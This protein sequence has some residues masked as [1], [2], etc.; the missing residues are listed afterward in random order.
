MLV[1]LF[2][3]LLSGYPVA[4]ILSGVAL[5]CAS[6]GYLFDVF[7]IQYLLFLPERIFGLMT[8]D[9][10]FSI[11]LFILM[12]AFL[13]HSHAAEKF[14]LYFSSLFHNFPAGVGI[15]VILVGALIAASTGVIGATVVAMGM[16][17]L[18]VMLQQHYH[19]RF[20]SGIVVAAGSLGQ[21][22]PPSIML[23]I[24]SEVMNNAYQEASSSGSVGMPVDAIVVSPGSFFA[25]AIL[26]SILLIIL[27]ILFIA[28]FASS[29]KTHSL[30]IKI[31]SS[32]PMIKRTLSDLLPLLLIMSVLG[33]ILSGV[34]TPSEASSIG[35]VGA[36]LIGTRSENTYKCPCILGFLSAAALFLISFFV[37]IRLNQTSFTLWEGLGIALCLC[38]F[39]L[40]FICIVVAFYQG[41]KSLLIQKASRT[42]L[43]FTGMIFMI[44]VGSAFFTLVLKGFGGDE[45]LHNFL[46]HLP[47]GLWTALFF[48]I[49]VIFVLGLFLEFIEIALVVLPLVS[50]PLMQ[51][52][53]NPVWLGMIFSLTLLTSFLTPPFGFALFYLRAVAPKE[54]MTKDIYQGALPFVGLQILALLCVL[55]FPWLATYLPK[56]LHL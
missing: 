52:G 11:P 24:L 10:F 50:V 55:F 22:I 15:S 54:I 2:C 18:P 21:I 25:A 41:W 9:T 13:Q 39:F 14:L 17:S 1:L 7:P 5:I 46:F 32:L 28:C 31:S 3:G 12:G 38:L 53:A 8:N 47:G 40:L 43:R 33:S 42:T 35:V 20:A 45:I 23:L 29:Q 36:L 44:F 6:L 48:V 30:T 37:D 49:L 19:P 16:V 56:I 51:L 4:F 34:A 26:P 27:Y